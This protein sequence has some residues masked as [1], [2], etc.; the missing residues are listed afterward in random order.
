MEFTK[1]E[2]DKVR[3]VFEQKTSDINKCE[4]KDFY[5]ASLQLENYKVFN[6]NNRKIIT[7]LSNWICLQFCL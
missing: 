7:I 4:S 2:W 1:E 6:I 5:W 3:E